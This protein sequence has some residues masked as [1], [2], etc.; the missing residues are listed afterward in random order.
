MQTLG[1]APVS[2]IILRA[3]T[4]RRA[5]VSIIILRAQTLGRAPV[6]IADSLA[7]HDIGADLPRASPL[8]IRPLPY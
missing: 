2:I 5:P 8:D 4:V 1:R 3:Q 6:S 7:K